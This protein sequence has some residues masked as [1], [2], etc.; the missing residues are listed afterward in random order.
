MNAHEE[1]VTP[2]PAGHGHAPHGAPALPFTEADWAEFH[3]SDKGA[4]GAVVVLMGAIFTIGL[5][6]YSTIAYLV[7]S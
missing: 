2:P 5:L 6:L 1:H 4:G 7:W 3:K